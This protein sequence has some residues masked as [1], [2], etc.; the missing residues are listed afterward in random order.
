MDQLIPFVAHTFVAGHPVVTIH[1]LVVAVVNCIAPVCDLFPFEQGDQTFALYFSRHLRPRQFQQRRSQIDV[2]YELL[3][4][5]TRL[6]HGWIADHQG[7]TV[8]FFVHEALVVPAVLTQVKALVAGVNDDGILGEPARFQVVQNAAY[9]AVH[10]IHAGQVVL[11]IA[12]VAPA[13]FVF[14]ST[15]VLPLSA[16]FGEVGF[17]GG[18]F[19]RSHSVQSLNE[20]GDRI[21]IITDEG[22]PAR[23]RVLRLIFRHHLQ[24]AA[25]EHIGDAHIRIFGGGAAGIIVAEGGGLGVA[26]VQQP[27][28]VGGIGHPVAVGGLVPVEH[29]KGL[30]APGIPL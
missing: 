24:V 20:S 12:L 2:E 16:D 3:G 22:G 28:Q 4:F 9:V 17:V 29:H 19:F 10:P 8:A 25:G 18:P 5:R 23:S 7:G 14:R 11:H 26:P 27:R 21:E 6:D 30:V 15:H 13:Q 1:P